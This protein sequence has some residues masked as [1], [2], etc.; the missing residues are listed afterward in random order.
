MY[1]II[2]IMAFFASRSASSIL[3]WKAIIREGETNVRDRWV[4]IV[5]EEKMPNT[6]LSVLEPSGEIWVVGVQRFLTISISQQ[7][8]KGP[9]SSYLPCA[10]SSREVCQ[11]A[12]SK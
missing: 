9:A 12:Q 8:Y 2:S 3:I 10:A 11:A 5:A 7:Q 1:Y 6:P 4:K